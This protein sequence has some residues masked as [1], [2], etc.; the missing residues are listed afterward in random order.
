MAQRYPPLALVATTLALLA[1]ILPSALRVAQQDRSPVLEYAPVP[2][3]D[4]EPPNPPPG[5]VSS[6]AL[7]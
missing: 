6:L 5:N 3:S 2:P 4:E 1:L 7:G